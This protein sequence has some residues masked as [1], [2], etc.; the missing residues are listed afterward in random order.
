MSYIQSSF[1]YPAVVSELLSENPA[2][3]QSLN[4]SSV[5]DRQKS[6]IA[7]FQLMQFISVIRAQLLMGAES[8]MNPAAF[9]YSCEIN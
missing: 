4:A 9:I 2:N 3:V 6:L 8:N 7:D 1:C 5:L